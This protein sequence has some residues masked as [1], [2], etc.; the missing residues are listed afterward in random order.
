M[1]INIIYLSF[2]IFVSSCSSSSNNTDF[3][4]N[5]FDRKEFNGQ[6]LIAKNNEIIYSKAFGLS[7]VEKQKTTLL[8]DTYLIGSLTKQFT[9]F[10]ILLLEERGFLE[11]H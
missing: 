7:N 6:V 9:S 1:K 5:Y 4:D 3:Y 11:S 10:S 2:T 8:N